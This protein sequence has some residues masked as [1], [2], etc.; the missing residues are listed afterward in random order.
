MTLIGLSSGSTPLSSAKELAGEILNLGGEVV[1]LRLKKGHRWEV[2]G[3]QPFNTA[4]LKIAFLGINT[5]LGD[6]SWT[7]SRIVDELG[8]YT[9]YPIKVFAN[10]GCM[11][12]ESKEITKLQLHLLAELAGGIKNVL[13]ETHYG[14]SEVD[15]L[16]HLHNDLG[17][18]IL[19]D[20]LGYYQISSN[21]CLDVKRLSNCVT[22]VQVKGFEWNL[23]HPDRHIP[24]AESDLIRTKEILDEL[25]PKTITIETKSSSYAEDF[26]ILQTIL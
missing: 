17:I 9:G 10:K 18:S 19:L 25:S 8:I 6:V 11:L 23:V 4:N 26:K 7:K 16:L 15:E 2:D 1:D 12:R 22:G 3:L 21:P 20:I 24:L 13:V 5:V 14:F